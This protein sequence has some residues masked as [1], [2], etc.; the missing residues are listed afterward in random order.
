MR[1]VAAAYP[2]SGLFV[3]A[4]QDEANRAIDLA[5]CAAGFFIQRSDGSYTNYHA[6]LAVFAASKTLRYLKYAE[7]RCTHDAAARTEECIGTWTSQGGLPA[8]FFDVILSNTGDEVTTR[9]FSNEDDLAAWRANRDDTLG[10]PVKYLRCPFSEGAVNPF[11]TDERSPL[12]GAALEDVVSEIPST[13]RQAVLREIL[14][15]LG[16]AWPGP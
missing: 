16:A 6:D 12:S 15:T 8:T 7:G 2:Y 10:Y 1:A 9:E 3:L 13:E 4:G 5:R 11:L 14:K